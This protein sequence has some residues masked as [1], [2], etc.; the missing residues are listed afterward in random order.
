MHGKRLIS[1]RCYLLRFSRDRGILAEAEFK[2]L[3]HL[4]DQA[5][6]LTWRFYSSLSKALAS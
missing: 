1:S 4:R 5:G 2:A 3:D 6:K